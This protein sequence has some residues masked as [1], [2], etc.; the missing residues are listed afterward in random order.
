MKNKIRKYIRECVN[1]LFEIDAAELKD[2]KDNL[3]VGIERADDNIARTKKEKTVATA[4]K[5]NTQKIKTNIKDSDPQVEKL[6]TLLATKE[7][8]KYKKEE[9]EKALL[10]KDLEN[11][12]IEDLKK[13]SEL[14]KMKPS[15]E[16][17]GTDTTISQPSTPSTP[18]S[19]GEVGITT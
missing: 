3:A 6:K 1:N 12:R 13:Q 2:M 10:Q 8:E 19:E 9:K 11:D 15:L 4:N 16:D 14:D 18:S 7:F 5:I 17:L